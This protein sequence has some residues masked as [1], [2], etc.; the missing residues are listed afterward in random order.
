[1][2]GFR[3]ALFRYKVLVAPGQALSAAEYHAFMA[4]LGA[5]V[6]HVL[7][8]FSLPALRDVLIVSN[9]YGADGEPIGVHEGGAY[10]HCDMSYLAANSVLTSLYA[11]S[12]R[13]RA[14]GRTSSTARSR[15]AR[16]S[17]PRCCASWSWTER[18]RAA[19]LRQ[20]RA[21]AR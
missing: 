6:P 9:V 19:P 1:M 14:G 11:S 10:W 3:A 12:R 8:Q 16:P 21:A 2:A 13:P 17:S 15:P 7:A 18:Q 20:P 4:R 5:P